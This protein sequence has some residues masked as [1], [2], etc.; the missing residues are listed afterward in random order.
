M[1]LLT[2]SIFELALFLY[3]F[4]VKFNSLSTLSLRFCCLSS[5]Y[6]DQ[7]VVFHQYERLI[8]SDTEAYQTD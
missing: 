4:E 6:H 7:Q 1:K 2:K 8:I 5:H 3:K